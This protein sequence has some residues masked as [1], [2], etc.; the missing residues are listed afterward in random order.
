VEY[1]IEMANAPTAKEAAE[2]WKSEDNMKP[3]VRIG[4][5]SRH[6]NHEELITIDENCNRGSRGSSSGVPEQLKADGLNARRKS[7]VSVISNE[8]SPPYEDSKI[9]KESLQSKVG[10]PKKL[11]SLYQSPSHVHHSSISNS[12]S[13]RTSCCSSRDLVSR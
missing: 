10:S 3:T 8:R 1:S 9:F 13:K 4:S 11:E 12:S 6:S 2:E 5:I 7:I